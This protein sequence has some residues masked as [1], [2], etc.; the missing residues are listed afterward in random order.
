M[1]TDNGKQMSST[2]VGEKTTITMMESRNQTAVVEEVVRSQSTSEKV[3]IW[4]PTILNEEGNSKMMDGI[5]DE[6][7]E[8]SWS[9]K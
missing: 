2:S 1:S 9:H 8:R 5:A 3:R 6:V 7:L 4:P